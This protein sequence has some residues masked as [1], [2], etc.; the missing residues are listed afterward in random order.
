MKRSLVRVGLWATAAA[1][2]AA[3]FAAYLSPHF[4]VDL[5]SRFWA[6]F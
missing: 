2:L 1:L 3:V 5:A 6:C 4:A